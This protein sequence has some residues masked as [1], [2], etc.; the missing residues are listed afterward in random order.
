[1]KLPV[2]P[3]VGEIRCPITG[4]LSPVRRDKRGKLYYLSSAGMIKPNLPQGQIWM[5][6]NSVMLA[7][8]RDHLVPVN[9][10]PAQK[11]TPFPVNENRETSPP[12]KPSLFEYLI[13]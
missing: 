10:P 4:E 13:G 5:Q 8:P 6:K 7:Q 2:N 1:M 9:E 12:K 3:D 11:Q